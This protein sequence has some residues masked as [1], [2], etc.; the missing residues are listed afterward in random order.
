MRQHRQQ[1]RA[2]RVR[3]WQ[4]LLVLLAVFASGAQQLVAQTHWHNVAAASEQSSG[5]PDGGTGR[6]VEGLLCQISAHAG[7]T[8]PP[9]AIQL[10]VGATN[11]HAVRLPQVFGLVLLPQPAYAWQSRGPPT[12]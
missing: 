6:H 5:A 4:L 2:S 11:V 9:A 7:A 10:A 12:V 8:S 1:R 3:T